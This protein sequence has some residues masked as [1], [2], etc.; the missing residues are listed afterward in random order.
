MIVEELI[1]RLSL[2]TK[3]IDQAKKATKEIENFRKALK[4][5][6]GSA[7]MNL[8]GPARAAKAFAA[9]RK[10]AEKV[11]VA[12]KKVGTGG[13]F[14]KADASAK[15]HLSTLKQ[16]RS[17]YIDT[18]K[19]QASL[20][21]G[22]RSG[23]GKSWITGEL[24]A[25]RKYKRELQEVTRAAGKLGVPR[26]RAERMAGVPYGDRSKYGEAI[27]AGT[28]ARGAG[29]AT[30]Y[31]VEEG[32]KTQQETNRQSNA[33]MTAEQIAVLDK[34]ATE[35]SAQ[36]PSVDATAVRTMGRDARNMMPDFDKAMEILPDLVQARVMLQASKGVQRLTTSCP[37]SSRP[38]TSSA[39]PR[40]WT[41]SGSC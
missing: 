20:G 32:A 23:G 29:Q 1:G 39:R 7:R 31:A 41:R 28:I 30:R 24:D 3:G 26:H 36:Y 11:A 5:L 4:S 25:L 21:R 27:A 12:Q 15:R 2:Q 38:Q 19:A 10:E 35:L 22:G 16:L 18:V 37:T 40:A 13:G 8:D 6:A 33:G 34:R 14:D 17:A 9:L